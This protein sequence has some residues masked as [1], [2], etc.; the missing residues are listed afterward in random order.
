MIFSCE[1]CSARY[2]IPDEKVHG[3]V[4]KVRCKKCS[5]VIVVR[6]KRGGAA[7]KS[8]SD[9]QRVQWYVAIKGKQ[10]GPMT[11]DGVSA[12]FN[13]GRIRDR[14]FVWHKGLKAW[15]R[16][17][18]LEESKDILY[19]NKGASPQPSPQA[20]SKGPELKRTAPTKQ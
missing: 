13:K 1:K 20:P 10:H 14:S 5:H 12:L 16:L 6:A 18:E 2:S 19:P 4:L 3:K 7:A 17:M 11:Q 15:T 8:S 9:S